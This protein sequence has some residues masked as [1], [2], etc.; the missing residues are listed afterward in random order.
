MIIL[1]FFADLEL[2]YLNKKGLDHFSFLKQSK[3]SRNPTRRVCMAGTSFCF[4]DMIAVDMN[5]YEKQQP[6]VLIIGFSVFNG[7]LDI[8]IPLIFATRA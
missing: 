3:R 2:D 4:G 6:T 1:R 7:F 5:G 8:S